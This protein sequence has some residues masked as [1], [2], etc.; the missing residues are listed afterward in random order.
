MILDVSNVNPI[1]AP[2]FIRSGSEALICKATEGTSFQDITLAEHRQIA[3]STHKVFGSYLFLHPNSKG[4]EAQYYL[5]YAKP[6]RGD[7][8]PIIDAEVTNMG[9][10]SLADRIVSCSD[11][12][13][14][15]GY[16][17][18]LYIGPSTWRSVV[19][20]RPEIKRLRIWE[21]QYPSRLPIFVTPFTNMFNRLR[22]RLAGGTVVM[23]QYTDKFVVGR[24]MYDSSK[25]F[26]ALDTL[27]IK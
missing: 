22:I 2:N 1:N 12:L 18:I 4:S 17:A 16:N 5:E 21:A 7:I 15:H 10:T 19:K 26:V 13:K 20:V 6:E 8:E 27:R 3:K 25:R 23:W 9:I 14:M 24:N 11:A